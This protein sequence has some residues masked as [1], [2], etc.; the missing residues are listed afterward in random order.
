MLEKE[1]IQSKLD[2][3]QKLA[4]LSEEEIMFGKKMEKDIEFYSHWKFRLSKYEKVLRQMNL[5]NPRYN[6]IFQYM[7]KI[8]MLF[9]S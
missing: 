9:G 1:T 7:Q 6:E 5:N 4:T 2:A 8:Y 3:R